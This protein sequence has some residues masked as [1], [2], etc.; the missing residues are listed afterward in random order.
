M[1]LIISLST[2]FVSHK[3]YTIYRGGG[4]GLVHVVVTFFLAFLYIHTTVCEKIDNKVTNYTLSGLFPKSDMKRRS[5]R[6]WPSHKPINITFLAGNNKKKSYHLHH[7]QSQNKPI[8]VGKSWDLFFK[9]C[10]FRRKVSAH[11][12]FF[13]LKT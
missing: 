13:P 6:Q 1:V 3:F 11:R 5:C 9:R 2:W 8:L 12:M 10:F 7:G 4:E